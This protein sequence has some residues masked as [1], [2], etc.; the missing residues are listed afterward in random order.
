[1]EARSRASVRVSNETDIVSRLDRCQHG[2][3]HGDG[4]SPC[5]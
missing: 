2:K 5:E 3:S 1:L 4:I